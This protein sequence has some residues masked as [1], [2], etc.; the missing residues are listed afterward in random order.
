MPLQ[1][2]AL[3]SFRPIWQKNTRV[4]ACGRNKDKL[5]AFDKRAVQTCQFDVNHPEEIKH[6]AQR[7]S[8]IDLLILNAGDCRYIDD[9]I[10][11]DG[12]LFADIIATNLTSMGALLEHFLPKVKT[13]GQVVFISSSAT[14]LPFPRSEAY[15]VS[16]AGLDYLANALRL[17]LVAH[18]IDVTLV[19]PGFVKN[20]VNR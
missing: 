1:A 13:G 10:S 3:R 6:A 8:E 18:Q 9:V 17:D 4:I 19:H 2:S 7:V 12:Q 20:P 5:S 16:K 11:F 15:G 14:L